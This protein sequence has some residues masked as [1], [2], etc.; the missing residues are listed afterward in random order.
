MRL[1]VTA[2]V[3]AVAVIAGLVATG[4][5]SAAPGRST[6][7]PAQFASPQVN[8]YFP[9]EPGTVTIFRGSDEGK[10]YHERVTVTH[11]TKT[12]EGVQTIVVHDVLRHS[13]GSLAEKTED[14]Y[15]ADN[16][17]NV[18]YFGESTAT[19]KP[20]GSVESREGSW[21]AGVHGATAGLIMPADPQPTKAY[22]QEFWSGHAEDQAWIVQSQGHVRTP[23]KSY[24]N[25]VR[26][27]EWTRLEP[28]VV[29]V[30]F[31][32]PGVGMVSERDVAGG[33]EKFY[34]ASSTS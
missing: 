18:W 31:Y 12:I 28:G 16:D 11:T 24:R 4:S 23:Y 9:L 20:N 26:S 21:Q 13:D 25:V 19:Y 15:A 33:S 30:K 2:S 7:D 6:P 27:Y 3:I 32:A 22:R 14:W 8:R 29:S 5:G 1:L 10:P 17:G 34:L